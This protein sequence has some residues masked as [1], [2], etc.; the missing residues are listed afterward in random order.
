MS[1]LLSVQDNDLEVQGLASCPCANKCFNHW[2]T[3]QTDGEYLE[4]E[5]RKEKGEDEENN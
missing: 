3:S 4:G 2:I 5:G 1:V